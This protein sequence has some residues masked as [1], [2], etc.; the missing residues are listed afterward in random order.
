MAL[1]RQAEKAL[2]R[3]RLSFSTRQ[4]LKGWIFVSPFVAGMVLFYIV[5]F[6]NSIRM[7]FF[8][9]QMGSEGLTESFIGLSNYNYAL[10]VNP[11]FVRTLFTS[12]GN[13][14]AEIPTIL[15]FSLFI[16]T[17]LNRPMRG[18]G[19]FR[20]I[21]FIPVILATGIVEKS[22]MNNLMMQSMNAGTIL[23]TTTGGAGEAMNL[24]DFDKFLTSLNISPQITSF[25]LDISNN[26]YEVVKKSGVQILVFLGGL[27]SINPSIYEGARIEG[28]S[29]WES[30]WKL[31]FPLISPMILANAIYTIIDSFTRPSNELMILINDV[32]FGKQA[33][34]G[35]ASAMSWIQTL[36]I[37][38]ILV[39]FGLAA[40]RLVFYDQK[41]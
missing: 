21:F 17:I 24:M 33:N 39:V 8:D 30:F 23:S 9:L 14:L 20:M 19:F 1:N 25:I 5:V 11:N 4:G 12:L 7:S 32:G 13:M 27:Q 6:I 37:V 22:E 40:S 36:L 15:L 41:E 38:V 29:G 3:S 31:T 10:R 34:F 28:A 16:A 2:R 18:R 35:G 26:I